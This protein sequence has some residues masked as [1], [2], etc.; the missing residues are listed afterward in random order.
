[1]RLWSRLFIGGAVSCTLAVAVTVGAPT[2]SFA[3]GTTDDNDAGRLDLNA[4]VLVNESVGS[5]AAGDFAIRGRLFLEDLSARAREQREA[6]AERLDVAGTLTFEPSA[7]ADEY[8]AVR[9]AL[10]DGYSSTVI[11]ETRE[12]REESPVLALLALVVGVPLV[13][14]GGVLLGRF[15]ARRRRVSA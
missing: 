7:V 12:A 5:G 10:F 11:S 15:W 8:Q 13:L 6:S 4:N 14:M 3:T 9:A 2:A 1:M